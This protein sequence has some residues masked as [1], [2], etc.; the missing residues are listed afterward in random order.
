M[1]LA[2]FLTSNQFA[3][4]YLHDES[5]DKS[6]DNRSRKNVNLGSADESLSILNDISTMTTSCLVYDIKILRTFRDDDTY[7]ISERAEF[8]QLRELKS[9]KAVIKEIAF[10]KSIFS[11]MLVSL[12][13]VVTIFENE[14]RKEMKSIQKKIS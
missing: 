9:L 5:V 8:K 2:K 6:R 4:Q 13:D 11:H 1:I 10:G 7:S 3:K 14:F 12:D